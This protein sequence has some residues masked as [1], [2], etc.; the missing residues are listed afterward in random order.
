MAVDP[1]T[2][3]SPIESLGCLFKLTEVFLR[4]DDDGFVGLTEYPMSKPGSSGSA[5]REP[6]ADIALSLEDIELCGQMAALGLP[7]A[8]QSN[9][10]RDVKAKKGSKKG[11]KSKHENNNQEASCNVFSSRTEATVVDSPTCAKN[12]QNTD[13]GHTDSENHFQDCCRFQPVVSYEDE[14][15]FRNSVGYPTSVRD[16]ETCEGV[17]QEMLNRSSTPGMLQD[18][19]EGNLAVHDTLGDLCSAVYLEVDGVHAKPVGEEQRN[20]PESSETTK[21]LHIESDTL[22]V[23]GSAGRWEAIWDAFYE[24][25]YFYNVETLETTWYPPSG[26]EHL[27]FSDATAK[28]NNVVADGA[29]AIGDV[30]LGSVCHGTD[31][32]N[33]HECYEL[34]DLTPGEKNVDSIH[35]VASGMEHLSCEHKSSLLTL[36]PVDGYKHMKE[37]NGTCTKDCKEVGGECFSPIP[38]NCP[39]VIVD[40]S[41]SAP[42]V[43]SEFNCEEVWRNDLQIHSKEN[44]SRSHEQLDSHPSDEPNGDK[45]SQELMENSDRNVHS[46]CCGSLLADDTGIAC[47]HA[48]PINAGSEELSDIDQKFLKPMVDELNVCDVPGNAKRKKRAKAQWPQLQRKIPSDWERTDIAKYW[49]QRYS[50]FARFDEGIKL[51]EEGWF[52]V[53]PESLAKHHASRCHGGI[54]IDCF[55]GVGGNA[56]QLARQSHHVIGIDIDP[57]KIDYAL[58]N[59]DIYG[60]A[61]KIDFINADFFCVAPYLKADVAFLSPPWGGPDYS[62]VE[63]YDI[64]TMLKPCDGSSLFNIARMIARKV[65]MFLPRNIDFNQLAEIAML[66]DP[67]WSLEVEK[68]YLNGKLKGITAYFESS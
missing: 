65:V 66:A 4:D 10:Q 53:T 46:N 40:E 26:M 2:R 57:Q 37:L 7:T 28:P 48:M 51:D 38:C 5:S 12:G 1:D 42:T 49:H 14:N 59:A 11:H 20:W 63:T 3:P 23:P 25:N 15:G 68:N 61:D 6:V 35:K 54:I 16:S 43:T 30:G 62:K 36:E 17:Y 8:F 45:S 39:S 27:V 9:N 58:H 21:H 55:T 24:R 47:L 67:P 60:V 41:C 34:N 44:E 33:A 19:R 22:T 50:L 52:S 56:I 29:G 13:L 32:V 31:S 18:K 64:R